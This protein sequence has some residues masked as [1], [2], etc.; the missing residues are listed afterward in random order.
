MKNLAKQIQNFRKGSNERS[1]SLFA[2]N[3]EKI[4]QEQIELK[5]KK[6]AELKASLKETQEESMFDFQD[7]L[8]Q[9]DMEAIKSSGE[10]KAYAETYVQDAL[11]TLIDIEDAAAETQA[12]IDGLKEEVDT[13]KKLLGVFGTLAIVVEEEK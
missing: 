1:V 6:I 8:V 5:T 12:E 7:S 2:D 10:R 9:I 13:L 4:V 11:N 3:A